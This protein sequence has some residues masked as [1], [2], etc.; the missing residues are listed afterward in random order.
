MQTKTMIFEA[1]NNNSI[2]IN[3]TIVMIL[4]FF[5]ILYHQSEKLV[6]S[7]I[8]LFQGMSRSSLC[9][10]AQSEKLLVIHVHVNL[11]KPKLDLP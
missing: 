2:T 3:T 4:C 7:K 11:W 8:S 1:I 9:D 10:A 6:G 5:Y